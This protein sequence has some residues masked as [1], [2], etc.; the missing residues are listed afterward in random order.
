M[1]K[2][3]KCCQESEDY[4]DVRFALDLTVKRYI[5]LRDARNFTEHNCKVSFINNGKVKFV[6]PDINC[7]LR[8]HPTVGAEKAFN[9]MDELNIIVDEL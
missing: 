7:N 6:Y 4:K 5:L 9:S 1:Y 3:R 8:L 2:A